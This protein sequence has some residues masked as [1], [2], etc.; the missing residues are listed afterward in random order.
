MDWILNSVPIAVV[1]Y[2]VC[3]NRVTQSL[4]RPE[5]VEDLRMHKGSRSKSG[6]AGGS[7]AASGSGKRGKRSGSQTTAVTW[8]QPG[9]SAKTLCRGTLRHKDTIPYHAANECS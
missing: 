7:R 5:P 6:T 3:T 9:M 1:Y 8:S 2:G 4:H